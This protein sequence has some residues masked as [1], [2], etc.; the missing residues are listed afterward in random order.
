MN[1]FF[2]YILDK[3]DGIHEEFSIIAEDR[4]VAY[5]KGLWY[6]DS[7]YGVKGYDIKVVKSD[8]PV[9]PKN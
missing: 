7:K 9:L 3:K 1:L 5:E 6:G 2:I 4:H 8:V